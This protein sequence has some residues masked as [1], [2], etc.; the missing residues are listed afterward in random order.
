MPSYAVN[1]VY[2]TYA[3]SGGRFKG[4]ELNAGLY[5]MFNRA[6]ASHSQRIAQYT[7]DNNAIDWEAG[8]NFK[9]NVSYKF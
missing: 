1:D 2:V 7:G 3:P 6:Y 5:N 8:R 4:L 9:L